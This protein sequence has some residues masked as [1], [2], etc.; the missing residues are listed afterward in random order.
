MCRLLNVITVIFLQIVKLVQ[1]YVILKIILLVVFH[2][3][4]CVEIVMIIVPHIR[5]IV[6]VLIAGS[7]SVN[8]TVF[9]IDSNVMIDSIVMTTQMKLIVKVCTVS[10][11][12]Y[13]GSGIFAKHTCTCTC[14]LSNMHHKYVYLIIHV[15][16]YM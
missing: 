15:H 12:Y 3:T 7:S 4:V 9:Q 10:E 5:I 1:H 11:I 8:R 16:V 6:I 14:T 2:W 13:F